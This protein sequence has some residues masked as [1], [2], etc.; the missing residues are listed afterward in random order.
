MSPD[1]ADAFVTHLDDGCLRAPSAVAK[2][3]H[4]EAFDAMVREAEELMHGEAIDDPDGSRC[5][6]QHS[7][8]HSEQQV[9]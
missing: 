1:L 3:E 5:R 8:V 2:R 6:P 7:P 9:G 4:G